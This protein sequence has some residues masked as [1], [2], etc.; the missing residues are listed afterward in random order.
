METT[1][2]ECPNTD[3]VQGNQKDCN[4]ADYDVT[5]EIAS[6]PEFKKPQIP[7]APKTVINLQSDV[8]SAE[9]TDDSECEEN[10]GKSQYSN[11]TKEAVLLDEVK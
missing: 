2:S 5:D 3:I 10:I 9:T 11:A 4:W 6:E 7:T 8:S 1:P